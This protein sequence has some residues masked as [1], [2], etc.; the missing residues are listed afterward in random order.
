MVSFTSFKSSS[1]RLDN[2]VST[3]STTYPIS[4]L[5][6]KYWPTILMLFLESAVLIALNTPGTLL[7]I[8][9]IR[10]A[11]STGGNAIAG[12]ECEPLVIPRSRYWNNLMLTSSPIFCCASSVEPPICGVKITLGKPCNGVV[13]AS[14]FFSGSTGNTSMPAPPISPSLM[15]SA[16]ALR[17]TTSPLA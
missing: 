1:A 4:S 9:K 5:V 17:S 8:C 16:S 7:C 12:T 10:C 3:S 11:P 6:F 14:P 2:L 15:A 13:N